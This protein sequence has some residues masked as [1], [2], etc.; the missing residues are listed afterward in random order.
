VITDLA[1]TTRLREARSAG[2]SVCQRLQIM[3]VSWVTLPRVGAVSRRPQEASRRPGATRTLEPGSTVLSVD[4]EDPATCWPSELAEVFERSVT[5]EYGSLTRSGRPITVPVSPYHGAGG[6][7]LDIS[8]G[9]TVP[10]K[11]DRARENPKVCLLYADPIG[12][13]MSKLPVV[14]VQG[15]AAVRDADLQRNM[16][17]YVQLSAAKYPATIKGVPSIVLGKLAYYY[18][19]IWIE[20]TP[21]RVRWWPNRHMSSEPKE[22]LAPANAVLPESDPAPTG[23]APPP[24]RQPPVNW[25]PVVRHALKRLTLSDLSFVDVDGYPV[26]LPVALGPLEG[27]RLTV[28]LGPG[29]PELLAGPAC[30][31]LHT[32]AKVFAGQENRTL[33]GHFLQDDS[34][35]TF[36]IERALGDWSAPGNKL[37]VN[38]AFLRKGPKLAPRLKAEAARRDQAVPRVRL[39]RSR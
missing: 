22:W 24:W 9:L 25:R 16:D 30:L 20:V 7:T 32:H 28:R 21:L 1:W 37:R 10:A 13:G 12:E 33:V 38:V 11:A 27:D 14:L 23:A 15:H 3:S 39:S 19:R 2:R 34:G 31:S 8:T 29:A 35:R 5:V 6:K 26:C 17:R 18:A 4:V 36:V